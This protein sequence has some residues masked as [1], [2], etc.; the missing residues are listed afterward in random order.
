MPRYHITFSCPVC[1]LEFWG[2]NKM[3][4]SSHQEERDRDLFTAH[5]NLN[6]L[7]E[8][9]CVRFPPFHFVLFGGKSL[10]KPHIGGMA[11][12]DLLLWW[13]RKQVNHLQLFC[14]DLSVLSHL[15]IYISIESWVFIIWAAIQYFIFLLKL[16]LLW[17]LGAISVT[18][19]APLT[20]LPHC[21]VLWALPCSRF[22]L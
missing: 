15:L 9:L 6:H 18:S 17:P 13:W 12:Y 16:F 2:G 4:F 11:S 19:Y 21:G 1:N 10:C 8:G 22:I 7:A 5:L 20:N 3:P 14:T